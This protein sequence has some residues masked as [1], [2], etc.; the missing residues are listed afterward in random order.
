MLREK[1]PRRFLKGFLTH[2]LAV[3]V[4]FQAGNTYAFAA[5]SKQAFRGGPCRAQLETAR[6]LNNERLLCLLN[7]NN[8]PTWVT[9]KDVPEDGSLFG[10]MAPALFVRA[11]VDAAITHIGQDLARNAPVPVIQT[12]VTALVRALEKE[13]SSLNR[14]IPKLGS[15]AA[16]SYLQVLDYLRDE[17]K[18]YAS[19]LVGKCKSS[20]KSQQVALNVEQL[21]G[22]YDDRYQVIVSRM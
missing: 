13:K 5:P 8:K 12:D 22:E 10:W 11:D 4:F 3:G 19:C 15:G 14:K 16:T 6:A 7:E 18:Q 2:F 9:K 21:I 20:L 1:M 17:L